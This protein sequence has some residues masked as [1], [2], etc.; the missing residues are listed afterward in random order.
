M[1]REL[2]PAGSRR[3]PKTGNAFSQTNPQQ[4]LRLLRSRAGA[5]SLATKTLYQC[6]TITESV[7]EHDF[8]RVFAQGRF[9]AY[10]L[11]E[12]P[13]HLL[14]IEDRNNQRIFMPRARETQQT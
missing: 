7:D 14:F 13:D 2:A 8:D 4:V 5:S 1:A 11:I 6:P 3:E 12:T 9:L 10:S